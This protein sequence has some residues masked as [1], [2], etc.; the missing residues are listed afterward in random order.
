ME[1]EKSHQVCIYSEQKGNY[2]HSENTNK[3]TEKAK[4][5]P[6]LRCNAY[7]SEVDHGEQQLAY[8]LVAT[9][10]SLWESCYGGIKIFCPLPTDSDKSG[11]QPGD[12]F[13]H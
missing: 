7:M 13:M 6:I 3:N 10:Y 8:Y 4:L 12:C 11:L 5:L 9:T 2:L 1:G